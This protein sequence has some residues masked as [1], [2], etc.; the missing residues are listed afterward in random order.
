L[1]S[2]V[3]YALCGAGLQ[4]CLV[5]AALAELRPSSSFRLVE[6]ATVGGNHTWCFYDSVLSPAA[7]RFVAPLVTRRWAGYEVRF[8]SYRRTISTPYSM[9]ASS[10][11]PVLVDEL[12]ARCSDS[13]VTTGV[14]TTKVGAGCVEL[15]D[16]ARIY[17]RVVVD[18]R[19]AQPTATR[20]G[21]QK[22]YGEEIETTKEH[23]I[24]LPIVMD[25]TIPQRD[26]FRFMYVLPL[27]ESRLLVEDTSFSDAPAL[28][29]ADRRDGIHAWLEQHGVTAARVVRR[30]QGVLPMPIEGPRRFRP[31]RG[32]NADGREALLGGYRGD[33][34]HPGTGYSLPM[35][36]EFAE[37]LAIHGPSSAR[38]PIGA[39][40][41]RRD[42]RAGFYHLLNRLMFTWYPQE[43]RRS[44]FERFYGFSLGVIERFYAMRSTRLD[45]LR[46][47]GGRPP[48]GLRWRSIIRASA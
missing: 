9:I 13:R 33:W 37:L 26:G 3:D 18:A 6:R 19:G 17:A 36:A 32:V 21:Y 40:A 25:A 24:A 44:I 7:R 43:M 45:Q 11:L 38:E 39:A 35:A 27:D 10:R 5:V 34:F 15:A 20:C 46:I 16:A 48:R 41:Y 42:R 30:E 23:G 12:A 29:I 14:A 4:N 28:D 2:T 31:A 22:F 47:L 8:P 1:P